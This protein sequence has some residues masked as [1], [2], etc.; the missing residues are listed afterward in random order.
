MA[1]SLQEAFA[2][3]PR[4]LE[5]RSIVAKRLSGGEQQMLA[6]ARALVAIPRLLILDE[7]SLGLSPSMVET[8]GRAI[9]RIA[10]RG[11]SI[12]LCEQNA[13]LALDISEYVYVM[14]HGE[15]AIEGL[16]EVL[17]RNPEVERAYFGA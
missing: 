14:E 11:V 17:R 2:L 9:T 7:P 6:I 4:L 1:E 10:Q 13:S 12:L 3:F 8:V 5:R 16:P 15:I